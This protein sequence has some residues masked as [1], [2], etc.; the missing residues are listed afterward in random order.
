[1]PFLERIKKKLGIVGE[2][3]SIGSNTYRGV[4]RVLD[5]GTMR[6]YLDDVEAMGVTRPGLLLVTHAD[7]V[8][9]VGNTIT[10]DG[11][12]YEVLKVSVHRIANT[13][14]AKIAVLA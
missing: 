4:F 6:A 1:M 3:F 13:A 2:Q 12:T 11:R 9:S 7:A 5:S 10:R 14:A 8:I